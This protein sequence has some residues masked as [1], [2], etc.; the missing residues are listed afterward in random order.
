MEMKVR[1]IQT[2]PGLGGRGWT[3]ENDGGGELKHDIL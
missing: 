1:S 3:K 2:I